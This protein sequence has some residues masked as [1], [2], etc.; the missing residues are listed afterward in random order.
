MQAVPLELPVLDALLLIPFW[1]GLVVSVPA[2]CPMPGTCG[3]GRLGPRS[4]NRHL[5]GVQGPGYDPRREGWAMWC[6]R[7]CSPCLCHG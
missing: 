4:W 6:E 5:R 3:S 7:R 2:S 1:A